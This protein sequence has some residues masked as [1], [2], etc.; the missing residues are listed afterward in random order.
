MT[1]ITLELPSVFAVLPATERDVLLREGVYTAVQA[2]LRRLMAEVEESQQH[3]VQFEQKYGLSFAQFEAEQLAELDS[4][5]A[6]EDYNDWFFWVE[7]HRVN[8]SLL[9]QLQQVDPN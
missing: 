2:R 8:Q 7:L 3:I 9:A 5:E 1:Q 4:L 6:H